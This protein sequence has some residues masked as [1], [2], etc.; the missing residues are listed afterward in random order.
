[1][2]ISIN[3]IMMS[4]FAVNRDIQH[5]TKLNNDASLSEEER[6]DHGQYVLDLT[7]VFG[8]LGMAYKEAWKEYPE[9]PEFDELVKGM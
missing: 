7:Q 8:E 6:A 1:M 4:L 5:F 9:F 2:N 3:A